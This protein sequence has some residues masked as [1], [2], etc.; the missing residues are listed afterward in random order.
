MTTN[1]APLAHSA[2]TGH[3]VSWS[4]DGSGVCHTCGERFEPILHAPSC[5]IDV[6]G[7]PVGQRDIKPGNV[8]LASWPPLNRRQ[9]RADAALARR[10]R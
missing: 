10:R 8:D 1:I 7:P 3:H 9:R 6:G 4:L 2:A 5:T